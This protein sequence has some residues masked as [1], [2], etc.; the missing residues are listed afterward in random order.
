MSN[1]FQ[2]FF[3]YVAF[4][5]FSTSYDIFC[6]KCLLSSSYY[7]WKLLSY[8]FSMLSFSFIMLYLF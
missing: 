5:A 8:I 6:L 3:C 1:L 7:S 2:S 4:R